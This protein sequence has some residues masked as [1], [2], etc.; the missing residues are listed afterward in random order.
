MA[1][2]TL[3]AHA[4]DFTIFCEFGFFCK[5]SVTFI[6]IVSEMAECCSSTVSF[7]DAL[8]YA[9]AQ[10]LLSDISVKDK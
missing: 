8:A 9:L 5:F 6:V 4:P 2:Y 7:S 10:L 1:W 3:F